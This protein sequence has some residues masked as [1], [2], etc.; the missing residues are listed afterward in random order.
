ME[1]IQK[2][3]GIT[4]LKGNWLKLLTTVSS[5]IVTAA[6]LWSTVSENSKKID[7]LEVFK[8]HQLS[9]N[10]QMLTELKNISN[11]LDKIDKHWSK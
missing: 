10:A 11:T 7:K 5:I 3:N 2:T 6:I 4:W 1:Q 9:L 8:D